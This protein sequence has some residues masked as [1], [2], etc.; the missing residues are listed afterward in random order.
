MS[1]IPKIIG[2]GRVK[3]PKFQAKE[4]ESNP[5]T[6]TKD[7]GYD[8][9][10]PSFRAAKMK[11]KRPVNPKRAAKN[12]VLGTMATLLT[13]GP[14]VTNTSCT[15]ENIISN[16]TVI[17]IDNFYGNNYGGMHFPDETS[18]LCFSRNN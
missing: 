14:I 18:W 9:F 7:Y 6:A 4:T 8:S 11:V 17:N 2:I 3:F 10:T 13:T 16:K 5:T 1:S 12:G 15:K